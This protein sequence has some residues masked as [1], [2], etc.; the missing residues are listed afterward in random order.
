MANRELRILASEIIPTDKKIKYYEAV[1]PQKWF[2]NLQDIYKVIK[3]R[4]KV[5]LPYNSLRDSLQALPLGII[6]SRQI[7]SYN[8]KP[9]ILSTNPIN[10]EIIL[11]VVKSWC[12]IEFISKENIERDLED[13]LIGILDD[14][15]GEDIQIEEKF[16]T[17]S[18]SRVHENGTAN[19]DALIYN[20]LG[21]YLAQKIAQDQESIVIEDEELKFLR[22]NNE[23]ISFPIKQYKDC[24]Y[25]VSIKFNVKTMAGYEKPILLVDSG[26]K[27]WANGKLSHSIG[28]KDNTTVLVKYNNRDNQVDGYTLGCDVIRRNY[29]EEC[30]EWAEDVKE[31]LEDSTLAYIPH[32][33]EVLQY[34]SEYIN[35]EKQ[36]S[37]LITYNNQNKRSHPVKKGLSMDEQ[38]NILKQINE[39][40]D[41]LQPINRNEYESVIR[42]Y[43]GSKL[44]LKENKYEIADFLNEVI[45]KE[46]ELTI[47]V[48]YINKNTPVLIAQEILNSI[49]ENEKLE[50]FIEKGEISLNYKGLKL[51]LK[52]ILAGDL[53]SKMTDFDLRVKEVTK[54]LPK[55]NGRIL[56]VV[57]I[58]NKGN[59]S[60][61]NDPKYAIRKGLYKTNRFNQFITEEK[62]SELNDE[63]KRTRE[64]AEKSIKPIIKNVILDLFRQSGIMIDKITLKGL[65]EMPENLEIIGFNLLSTN[66][67]PKYDKLSFPVAVSIRTGE[68]E[69]YVKTPLNDDWMLYSEAIIKLGAKDNKEK[70]YDNDEIKKFFRGILNDVN[71]NASLVLVDTSNRLNSILTDFQDKNIKLNDKY[72]EYENIRMIRVKNNIDVPKAV[73]INSNNAYFASGAKYIVG[74]IYYSMQSKGT[75]YQSIWEKDRKLKA[76]NKEFKMPGVLEIVPVRLDKIDNIESFVYFTHILRKLNISYGELTSVPMV[77]HLA[78]SFREVLSV[79][80]IDEA[81]K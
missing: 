38:Y 71:E 80:D 75:T 62:I 34:S 70:T 65:K 41:F 6:C 73:G 29:R 37:M 64:T 31:I 35:N 20:I 78:K 44:A 18:E 51:N 30:Y 55:S 15:K 17:L 33:N 5:T 76:P 13:K 57:E 4:D 81:E 67:N 59:Y 58:Y 26:I 47:E 10:V 56:S 27:R 68:K 21:N 40:F 19:P 45:M 66:Y 9:W 49:N 79:N 43:C 72:T 69:I 46:K 8:N 61:K 32:L 7:C 52:A 50:K 12:S 16:L 53:V 77:N 28:Y 63:N 60:N 48:I 25:S 74:N 23:L 24:Y 54:L 42:K 3:G 2:G 39:K 22:Y 1:F 11:K 36:Y 14:L